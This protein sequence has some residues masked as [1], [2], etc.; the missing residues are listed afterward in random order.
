MTQQWER[1]ANHVVDLPG[2][3]AR[4]LDDKVD[5]LQARTRRHLSHPR[6]FLSFEPAHTG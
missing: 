3:P 2:A 1:L 6:G 4:T 5:W